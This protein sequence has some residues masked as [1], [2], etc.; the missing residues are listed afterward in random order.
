LEIYQDADWD[1]L[2]TEIT[3]RSAPL[4]LELFAHRQAV[5]SGEI[6]TLD[7][8]TIA[9][10][11]AGSYII[12]PKRKENILAILMTHDVRNCIWDLFL[13]QCVSEG[14]LKAMVTIPFV[15]ELSA[16]SASSQ[17]VPNQTNN[18]DLLL[19]A[20]RKLMGMSIDVVGAEQFLSMIPHD[21]FDNKSHCFGQIVA[22]MLSDN[23]V[24]K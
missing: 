11:S 6:K 12:N 19:Y 9:F 17:I 3:V 24:R 15:T 8:Q 1:I 18:T 2:F 20:F 13:S 7:L 23:F 21:Y 14:K 4:M 22:G 16:Y 5:A 10:A